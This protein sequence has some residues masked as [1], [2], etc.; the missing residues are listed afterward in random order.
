VLKAIFKDALAGEFMNECYGTAVIARLER[1]FGKAKANKI[2]CKHCEILDAW[3]ERCRF[4]PD[5]YLI[6]HDQRTVVC[7]EIEDWNPMHPHALM[8][9][10]DA[11]WTLEAIEWDLHLITYDIYGH[12]REI[13]FPEVE[14]LAGPLTE[15]RVRYAY[16]HC[17][18]CRRAAIRE[19]A[20]AQPASNG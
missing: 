4:I 9:Y 17:G 20:E 19:S 3:K 18:F 5:A 1:R 6:D 13:M 16:A 7:Y 10:A 11:W 15:T 2:L 12:P 8:R 14:F